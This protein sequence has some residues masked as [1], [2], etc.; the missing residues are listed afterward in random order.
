MPDWRLAIAI[1]TPPATPLDAIRRFAARRRAALAA[2]GALA[3]TL[4]VGWSAPVAPPFGWMLGGLAGVLGLG[5][6]AWHVARLTALPTADPLLAALAASLTATALLPALAPQ[7]VLVPSIL[8]I[9]TGWRRAEQRVVALLVQCGA[10]AAVAA[11]IV[12]QIGFTFVSVTM[13]G[14]AGF[15]TLSR[16]SEASNDNPSMERI[17]TNSRLMQPACY[18][19][20]RRN[21]E[22]GSGE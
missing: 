15:L 12:N 18:A 21:P 22:S 13:L 10:L 19:R 17:L 8:A 3:L 11:G 14:F 4:L 20:E 7:T 1:A 2:L 6:L 16:G 5:L 9:L